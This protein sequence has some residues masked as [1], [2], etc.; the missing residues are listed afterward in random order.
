M[1]LVSPERRSLGL[2][3]GSQ[4]A[5]GPRHDQTGTAPSA[6]PIRRK[7]A[8]IAPEMRPAPMQVPELSS[9][10]FVVV[11]AAH[12]APQVPASS[13]QIVAFFAP[14]GVRSLLIGVPKAHSLQHLQ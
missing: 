10:L 6:S 7:S 12:G 9:R 11:T 8:A 4:E 1:E 3:T 13:S 5:G 14:F 2:G